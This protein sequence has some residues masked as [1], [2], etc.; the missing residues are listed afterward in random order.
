VRS[1]DTVPHAATSTLTTRGSVSFGPAPDF[2]ASNSDTNV[3]L[4]ITNL[5]PNLLVP[6]G[7]LYVTEIYTTHTLITPFNRIGSIVPNQLH[8]IAYF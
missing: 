5:Q 3:N 1:K 7:M 6:G 8:S 2:Q 4:Q